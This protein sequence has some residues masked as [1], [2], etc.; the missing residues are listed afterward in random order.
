[1]RRITLTFDNGP[2]PDTTPRVLDFLA[3]HDILATFFALGSKAVIERNA[4]LLARAH[5][6]GHWVGN[7][8]WS[9]ST[10]LGELDEALA[11]AELNRTHEALFSLGLTEKLFR[12]FGRAGNIGT[13]LLNPAAVNWLKTHEYSCVLWNCVPGDWWD[14]EG[15]MERGIAQC[16]TRDWSLVVLHDLPT[17]AMKHLGEFILQLKQRG[18]MFVQAFPPDCVPIAQGQIVMPLDG[19]VA[20]RTGQSSPTPFPS[21]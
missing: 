17:G 4:A 20:L 9:H 19:I 1:M 10:P 21:P 11:L 14:P 16:Q 13:H 5:Q 3:H 6:A 8:T 7:H 12:P 2:D 18:F 15:W